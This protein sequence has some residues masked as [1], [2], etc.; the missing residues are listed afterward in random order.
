M[1]T[2]IHTATFTYKVSNTNTNTY[3]PIYIHILTNFV[4]MK[5]LHAP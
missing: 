2:N 5:Q 1:H 3:S 4:H